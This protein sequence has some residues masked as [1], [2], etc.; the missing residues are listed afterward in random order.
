[1]R[2]RTRILQR[3]AILFVLIHF[4]GVMLS[5][6]MWGV[7]NSNFAG[8]N[9]V[10]LNPS[11]ILSSKL[12]L[13]INLFT[14]D[15]FVQNNYLYIHAEDYSIFKFL[16]KDPQFPEYGPDELPFD[17][18]TSHTPKHAYVNVYAKGPS[19]MYSRG[20][21]A[22]ALHTGVRY[23]TSLTNIPYDVANLG[24][25]GLDYQEQHNI[26]YIR[27][28]AS[29]GVLAFGEVGV[30]YAYAF[31]QY[32]ME[33]W[34]AGITVKRLFGISGAYLYANDLNYTVVNDSTIDFKNINAEFGYAIPLDYNTNDFPD[35][36]PTLKGGGFGFD[37]GITYQQ[38]LM[39][40]QRQRIG[41]SCNQR[42]SDYIFK[43]GVS[44]LDLG[45]VKFTNNA[46]MHSYDDVSEYWYNIDTISYS[47]MNSLIQNI[48]GT[49]NIAIGTCPGIVNIFSQI[50]P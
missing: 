36:G 18:K 26:N 25:Y 2:Y 38:K 13:D 41:R 50:R 7:V 9:S 33:D 37:L 27:N 11:G 19:F 12:Y 28:N 44:L 20:K 17:R 39:T 31:R 6:E 24:Y 23:L 45:S 47:N 10:M 14:S 16:K 42:Y 49:F 29:V 30:S 22:I 46:Q 32:N 21:H 35:S 43:V 34:S 8:S 1:M 15:Y 48:P 4:A 3:L 5:Q 40:H